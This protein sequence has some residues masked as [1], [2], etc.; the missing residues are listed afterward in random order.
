V[1]EDQVEAVVDKIVS[2]FEKSGESEINAINIG[3]EVMA[4]LSKLD[5]V[6]YIRFASVYKDFTD[7]K[8]F[9]E[10]VNTIKKKV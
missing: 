6:A 3:S 5:K 10:F 8:D 1:T 7:A 2:K 4:E 9:E